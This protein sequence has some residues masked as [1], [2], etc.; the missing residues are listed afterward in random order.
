M[1]SIRFE[2]DDMGDLRALLDPRSVRCSFASRVESP[3]SNGEAAKWRRRARAL[4]DLND[5]LAR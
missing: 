2:V 3:N 4:L 5:A 1:A